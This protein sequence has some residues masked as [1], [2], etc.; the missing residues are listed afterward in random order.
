MSKIKAFKIEK[1]EYVTKTF[2]L[3]KD[4][5]EN[6]ATLAQK[7][8]VSINEFVVQAISF[9][10]SYFISDSIDDTK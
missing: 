3:Q 1:T 6:I 8:E 7:E 5:Y 2:R 4:L 9:A 10:L